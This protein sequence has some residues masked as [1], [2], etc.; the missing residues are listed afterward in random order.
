MHWQD[1]FPVDPRYLILCVIVD[2]WTKQNFDLVVQPTNISEKKG[3]NG[4]EFEGTQVVKKKAFAYFSY[5]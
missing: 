5:T 4:R 2:N 3:K 1:Q